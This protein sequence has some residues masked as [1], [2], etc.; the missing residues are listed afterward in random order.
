MSEQSSLLLAICFL[1]DLQKL[2]KPVP[3]HSRSVAR[4][5]AKPAHIL[6]TLDLIDSPAMNVQG[7]HLR[8]LD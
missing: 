7:K 8:R 5:N 3:H 2:M 6:K 4:I 1:Y